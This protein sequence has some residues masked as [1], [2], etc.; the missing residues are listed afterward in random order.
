[1]EVISPQL[2]WKEYDRKALPMAETVVSVKTY[3]D[4]TVKSLYFNGE[5]SADGCARI[6]GCLY[7]PKVERPPVILYLGDLY[8]AVTDVPENFLKLGFAVFKVD[9]LGYNENA[10][11]FSIYPPSMRAADFYRNPSAV[12]L[13]PASPRQSCWFIW[14][15]AALRAITYL[16]SCSEVDISRAGIFGVGTGGASVWKAAWFDTPLKFGFTMFN[17]SVCKADDGSNEAITYKASLDIAAYAHNI[18]IPVF[19]QLTS[20]DAD[21][22]LDS[23]SA[24]FESASLSRLS[25]S[26]RTN[27]VLASKQAYNFSCA[28]ASAFAGERLPATPLLVARESDHSFYFELK[29]DLSRPVESVD[30]FVAQEQRSAAYRNWHAVR[31]EN[32]GE[33]EYLAKIDVF[34]VKEPVYGFAN[35]KYK[36]SVSISSP[37]TSKI[38]AILGVHATETA[39]SRLVYDS[40]MG[41]DDWLILSGRGTLS[42]EQGPFG[43]GGV[44]SSTGNLST[45]KIGDFMYKGGRDNVLQLLIYSDTVQK[46]RFTVTDSASYTQ[47]SAERNIAPGDNWMKFSLSAEDFKS[48]EGSLPGWENVVN[49]EISSSGGTLINSVIWV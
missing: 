24:A 29:I 4:Y 7:L 9:Y 10:E 45:F 37:V 2:L 44:T 21:N 17:S 31:L 38:P 35:V 25:V 40:D 27:H 15:T 8:E 11:R 14:A 41:L 28:A 30:L 32:T 34:E 23:M 13:P 5:A 47:F 46:I 39:L 26:E 6:F 20:N 22:S 12:Y 36:D 16:E 48:A 1:M 18:K 43:I 49:F 3:D 33:G 19:I 42:M